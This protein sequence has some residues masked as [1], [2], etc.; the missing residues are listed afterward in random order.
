MKKNYHLWESEKGNDKN[1]DENKKQDKV[2]DKASSSNVKIEEI[3]VVSEESE[4]GE[5]LLILSL[6][7]A[8]L[9]ATDD[10]NMHD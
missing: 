6:D 7:S 3:N 9:V 5:I 1:H 2:K 4:D 8:Q 10:L